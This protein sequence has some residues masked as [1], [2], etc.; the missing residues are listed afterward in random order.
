[1]KIALCDDNLQDLNRIKDLVTHYAGDNPQAGLEITAYSNA[2]DLIDDIDT[3]GCHF[4]AF[5]LDVLMADVNGITTGQS[6][7]ERDAEA[8]IVYITSSP[9]FALDAFGV[10]ALDYLIKP[11][12][13]DKLNAALD[14]IVGKFNPTLTL[15]QF[16]ISGD[17]AQIPVDQI[18]YAENHAR[19]VNI[20][21]Q[22][23]HRIVGA[24]NRAPFETVLADL[25][26]RPAFIQIH[27]SY[28]VNMAWIRTVNTG[29][30]TMED[31]TNL[32]ISRS[33][34][35]TVKRQ[36]LAYLAQAESG[37]YR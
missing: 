24:T 26:N 18:R 9:E 3:Q 25:L 16:K 4:D 28:I 17:I 23:Q 30:V 21:V 11:L 15:F 6:I 1:M 34:L 35:T 20:I 22:N 13:L 33:R 27:K 19:C 29:I 36:W 5:L 10:Q 32:R 12:D 31:G 37:E 7:R 8:M 14:R 2:H